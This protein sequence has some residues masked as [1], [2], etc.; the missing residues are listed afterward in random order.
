MDMKILIDLLAYM[1]F[2]HTQVSQLCLLR[3]PGRNDTPIVMSTLVPRSW[4]P[5]TSLDKKNQS[6][7]EKWLISKTQKYTKKTWSIL[8]CQKVRKCSKSKMKGY[9]QGTQDLT[10]RAPNGQSWRK[11]RNTTNEVQ[12]YNPKY[13]TIT[14]QSILTKNKQLNRYGNDG[15]QTSLL[16]TRIPNNYVDN[17]LTMM[18]SITP[19]ILNLGYTQ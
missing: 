17:P 19:H 14:H 13:E 9:V 6:S 5:V 2:M 11:R 12:N 8:Q 10:V 18:W 4:F 1:S 3:Q 15:E 7:L 16:Y